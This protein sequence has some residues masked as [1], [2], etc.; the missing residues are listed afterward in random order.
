MAL[1]PDEQ[2]SE[3]VRLKLEHDGDLPEVRQ[4][5]VMLDRLANAYRG[6]S[7]LGYQNPEYAGD[8]VIEQIHVGSL[9]V[10]F[11][12][13]L[14]TATAIITLYE[15][16][17]LLGGF[18]TQL[19]DALS[20]VQS[21]S[22][23]P[24]PMYRTALEALSAPVRTGRATTVT[25]NVVGDNNRIL[26]IDRTAAEDIRHFLDSQP[27]PAPRGRPRIIRELTTASKRKR[28]KR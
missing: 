8:L 26:I 4:T 20:L 28:P 27:R 24:L 12:D 15:H 9:W 21:V 2:G 14:E 19:N 16:R 3:P 7:R 23:S 18:V 13:V 6:Y 11:R 17:E 5:G 25:L 1:H 22:G 10:I